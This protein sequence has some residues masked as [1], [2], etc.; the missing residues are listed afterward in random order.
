MALASVAA[1]SVVSLL[2][3]LVFATAHDCGPE[4]PGP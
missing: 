4:S 1:F 3:V 2:A